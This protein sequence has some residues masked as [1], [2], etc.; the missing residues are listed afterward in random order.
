MSTQME[1]GFEGEST[2][3]TISARDVSRHDQTERLA[4]VCDHSDRE[5]LSR[6]KQA[7]LTDDMLGRLA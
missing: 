3:L 6:V 7:S 2:G 5:E 4:I 1:F